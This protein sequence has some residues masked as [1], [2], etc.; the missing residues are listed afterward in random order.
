MTSRFADV[1]NPIVVQ[2]CDL[3]GQW[4]AEPAGGCHAMIKIER[5]DDPSLAL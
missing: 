4:F 5:G 3:K 2:T 1:S